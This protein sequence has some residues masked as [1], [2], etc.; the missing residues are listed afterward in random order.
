MEVSDLMVVTKA[1]GD[2]AAAAK[3][4]QAEYISALKFLQPRTEVWKPKVDGGVFGWDYGT[5]PI[6]PVIRARP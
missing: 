2:L 3:L 1:D 4:T 5:C 6:Y